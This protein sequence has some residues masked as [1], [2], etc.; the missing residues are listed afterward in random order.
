M[1]T[2]T[3][4]DAA[5]ITAI[6]EAQLA[7]HGGIIGIRD[8]GL[9]ESALM[10]PQNLA[11]YETPD[12]A[13]L[14]AAYGYGISRNHPYLDGNKRTA[15]VAVEL[16]LALNGFELVAS[17]ADCVMTMLKVAAGEISEDAFAEWIRRNAQTI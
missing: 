1:T 3:W 15:F 16:F 12:A 4:I 10:R 9:L 11:Q 14:A 6:H 17:D 7:E 2:W 5:V 13:A 8:A